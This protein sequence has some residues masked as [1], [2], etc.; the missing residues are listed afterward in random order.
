MEKKTDWFI[1]DENQKMKDSNTIYSSTS[2]KVAICESFDLVSTKIISLSEEQL[3]FKPEGKWSPAENLSHLIASTFPISSA[4]NKAKIMFS[5]FG[6]SKDGSRSYEEMFG[7]YMGKLDE[8][9]GTAGAGFEPKA[10]DVVDVQKM[11]ENWR[12]I[13]SKFEA[14]LDKWSE[15]DLDKYRLPHPLLGKMTFREILFF[16]HFHNMIHFDIINQ[17]LSEHG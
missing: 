10:E 6:T 15:S 17:R 13:A 5:V 11:L 2:I 14:R 1:F 3:H 9:V 8:G 4:L 12:M 16:T 7:F